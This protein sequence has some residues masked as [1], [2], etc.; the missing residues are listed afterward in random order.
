[1]KVSFYTFGCTINHYETQKLQDIFSANGDEITEEADSDVVIINSCA[2]TGSAEKNVQRLISRL[3]AKSP[4]RLIAVVGCYGEMLKRQGKTGLPQADILLGNDKEQIYERVHSLKKKDDKRWLG[5]TPLTNGYVQVQNG[6]SNHCSYCIVPHLRGGSTSVAPSTIQEEIHNLV[7]RGC[8]DI[9]LAGINLGLY[10]ADGC[11]LPD[12][13]RMADHM[14]GVKRIRLSSLEPMNVEDRLIQE[15]GSYNKLVSHLHI[16]LQSGCDKT[17]NAMNRNY[18]FEE[19]FNMLESIRAKKPDI[20]ISTDVIV[21]FPGETESDFLESLRNIIRCNFSDIHIFKFSPRNG[22]L[23]AA[24]PN[25]VTEHQKNT[26]AAMLKGVKWQ[27]SFHYNSGFVGK[28]VK[29]SSLKCVSEN[30]W[31]GITNHELKILVQGTSQN[32]ER[33]ETAHIT[34]INH[35]QILLGK[36]VKKEE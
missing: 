19:F 34:G 12:I 7:E 9:T 8:T 36:R 29:V 17:L 26:R 23:A 13:I 1:M 16:S 24:M 21:G 25:Q 2:V 20:A 15:I 33:M 31:E 4:D 14:P 32:I 10:E 35:E 6:C 5:T 11:K 27:A 28:T 18:R 3:R 22:T 30:I